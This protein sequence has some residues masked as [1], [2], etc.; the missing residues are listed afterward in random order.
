MTN[1][2]SIQRSEVDPKKTYERLQSLIKPLQ[3]LERPWGDCLTKMAH[4][5]PYPTATS[6]FGL[7]RLFVDEIFKRH[8]TRLS[9]L[10]RVQLILN[11]SVGTQQSFFTPYHTQYDGQTEQMNRVLE[12]M[13]RHYVAPHPRDWIDYLSLAEFDVNNF[14]TTQTDL[15]LRWGSV[16]VSLHISSNSLEPWRGYTLCFTFLVWNNLPLSQS[17]L[18][19]N[20]NIRLKWC[21]VTEIS[22]C[23]K[24]YAV[25]I[26][27]D[28]KNMGQSMTSIGDKLKPVTEYW[29]V[30]G[31]ASPRLCLHWCVLDPCIP[32]MSAMV[33]GSML[34]ACF[35]SPLWARLTG[36][37]MLS[38]VQDCECVER[39]CV[40]QCNICSHPWLMRVWSVPAQCPEMPFK[41]IGQCVSCLIPKM[42]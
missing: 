23:G 21:M 37:S 9:L 24:E 18:M 7:A 30:L 17:W 32:N 13:L 40:V 19:V 2:L 16:W 10:E 42:W 29:E 31:S 3:I 38:T 5:I 28:G 14:V 36:S 25:S 33:C 15:D 1:L 11:N 39:P 26:W 12:D 8:R 22:T 34:S 6:T 27:W 4:F 20:W 41:I 35:V